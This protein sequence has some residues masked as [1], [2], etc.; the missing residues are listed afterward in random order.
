MIKT[1]QK[2]AK[3]EEEAVR[4]ALEELGLTHDDVSVE[5]IELAKSGVLGFGAKPAVVA[6]SYEVSDEPEPKAATTPEPKDSPKANLVTNSPRSSAPAPKDAAKPVPVAVPNGVNE[7]AVQGFISGL[8]ERFGVPAQVEVADE[9]DGTINVV[10]VAQEAGALIGRRGE[11]LD[12]IQHLTNYAVNSADGRRLRINVDT[13]NYRA[14]R[15]ETLEALASKT[16]SKVVKYRRNLTLDPMNAYE[17][18][19]IHTALQEHELVSTHSVGS[20]P[21]RRVVVTY[22]KEGDANRGAAR[23]D[24]N[25]GGSSRGDYRGGGGNRGG[26][27]PPRRDSAPRR[28][29]APRP[30]P[31]KLEE[32]K[33]TAPPTVDP[34]VREWS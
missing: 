18:H 3:T 21:N 4:L 14:R 5:I 9:V 17:R 15:G 1:I 20:E 10:L 27:R 8:L 26:S 22:G 7:A 12:A 25:R 11:T 13:E 33:P 6:I 16:A 29:A 2:S 28:D 34:S 24:Y 31:V 30:E 23:G 32:T 19:V